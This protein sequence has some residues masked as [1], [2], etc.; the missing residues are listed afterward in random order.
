LFFKASSAALEASPPRRVMRGRPAGG[1]LGEG[2]QSAV[3][4]AA[5]TAVLAGSIRP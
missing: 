3:L 5:A 2:V 4:P 1:I